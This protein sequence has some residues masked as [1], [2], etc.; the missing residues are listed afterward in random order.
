M[1][2]ECYKLG[3]VFVGIVFAEVVFVGI[4]FVGIV[5][6]GI[7]F[8]GIIR[9]E[10][11]VFRRFWCLGVRFRSMVFLTGDK[12]EKFEASEIQYTTTLIKSQ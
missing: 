11:C 10:A 7:V 6:V 12:R 5:F 3:G 9:L 4:V 2:G 1:L 8:V